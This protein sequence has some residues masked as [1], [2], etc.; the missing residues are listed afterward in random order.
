MLFVYRPIHWVRNSFQYLFGFVFYYLLFGRFELFSFIVGMLSFLIAYNGIYFINDLID[1]ERDK[2]DKKKHYKPLINKSVSKQQAKFYIFV[3]FLAGLSLSLFLN[4]FFTFLLISL[5]GINLVHTL[6]RDRTNFKLATLFLSQFIKFSMGWFAL[7]ISLS[8]FPFWPFLTLTMAYLF[9]Y[10][11]YKNNLDYFTDLP[12]KSKA[13]SLLLVILSLASYVA[14]VLLSP[15]KLP[16]VL[17]VFILP[18]LAIV[19]YFKFSSDA[20][21]EKVGSMLSHLS[22]LVFFLLFLL[23]SNPNVAAVN[24]KVCQP[25]DSIRQDAQ[26][27]I[28]G[29]VSD[30]IDG[31]N[32]SI[33]CQVENAIQNISSISIDFNQT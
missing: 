4:N 5:I 12:L 27:A 24:E 25:L 20:R 32:K 30:V 2:K 7:T 26:N 29:Q 17:L 33:T 14:S 15:F 31:I 23:L 16:W 6:L 13:I 3:S 28:P 21:G 22:L 18:P 9:N 10:F 11:A 1:Y 19:W 8:G